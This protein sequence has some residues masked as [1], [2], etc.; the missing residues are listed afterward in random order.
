MVAVPSVMFLGLLSGVLSGSGA[1]NPWYAVLAKPD[2]TPPGWVFG[3]VWPVLYLLIGLS[4]AVVL[5]ARRAP[6]RG[7]A[8]MLFIVQLACNLVWSPL[9]FAAHEVAL[10]AYLAIVILALAVL[11]SVYFARI[12][13]VA[14]LLMLPYVAWLCFAAVLSHE[15][16]DLNP[17]AES[18]VPPAAHTQI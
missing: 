3:A 9:F 2:F 4:L 13:T 15:M 1:N 17:D 6:G 7:I 14:A 10:A 18:L 11:T 8:I 16:H 5:N 12:R